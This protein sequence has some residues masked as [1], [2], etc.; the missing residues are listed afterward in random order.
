M[1][2]T[3][4]IMLGLLLFV[5][6]QFVS[7]DES[8]SLLGDLL[9]NSP[10]CD[11]NYGNRMPAGMTLPSSFDWRNSILPDDHPLA[12]LGRAN[13]ISPA[14][15][16]NRPV[17]C[18]SCWIFAPLNAIEARYAIMYAYPTPQLNL[19]EQ[20]VL[21]CNPS[22]GD[23]TV[24]SEKDSHVI[25]YNYLFDQ[26]VVTETCF[27]YEADDTISCDERCTTADEPVYKSKC[28]KKVTGWTWAN[29]E[30]VV[31]DELIKQEVYLNGPVITAV[32]SGTH[33]EAVVGWDDATGKWILQNSLDDPSWEYIGY[34]VNRIGWE[35]VAIYP[36]PDPAHPE[37]CLGCRVGGVC[38]ED[39]ELNPANECL[40]CNVGNTRI[41]WSYVEG[42]CND[43]SRCTIDD[44]CQFGVCEGTAYTCDDGRF[45]TGVE[46]CD[47]DGGCQKGED[48]CPAGYLCNED[49]DACVQVCG[50]QESA[51]QAL[52][53]LLT[54]M[55][56]VVLL[57]RK[58]P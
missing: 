22:N 5:F 8:L 4:L 45:C 19:S 41:A 18:G 17:V 40:Q 54:L 11:A 12:N 7:A 9:E 38:Y 28:Y 29:G 2:R 52:A 34:G 43:G 42:S 51:K 3:C 20:E 21:S 10:V 15:N 50:A 1:K 48:P 53:Y 49:E 58:R 30:P 32:H 26:G 25:T 56:G 23:C 57:K 46:S 35:T 39:G 33:F 55:G 44:A 14:Q 27:P 13:Y 31:D 36:V 37:Y 24:G 47:E 6:T 16:Q